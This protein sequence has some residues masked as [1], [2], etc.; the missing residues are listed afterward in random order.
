[1][2]HLTLVQFPEGLSRRTVLLSDFTP[3]LRTTKYRKPKLDLVI[4]GEVVNN[5]ISK[6][7]ISRIR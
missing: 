1:M 7:V 4:E 6:L 5:L 2:A 3:V